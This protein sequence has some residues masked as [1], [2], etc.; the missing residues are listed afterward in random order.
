MAWTSGNVAEAFPGVC[1]PLG[2]SFMHAPV[3]LAL[4][5]A[6]RD[7]GVFTAAQVYQPTRVEE[8]FWTAFAGRAAANMDQFRA[9]ADL[10]P[11]TS[12]TAV[13]QQLFGYVRPG[14]VDRNS[15]RRYPAI[16]VKAPAVVARLGARHDAHFAELR[17]WRTATLPG[18]PALDRGGCLLVLA[19]ARARFEEMMRLHFL[20]SFVGNG[21][22]ERLT[23]TAEAVGGPAL[24]ARLLSGVGSDENQVAADLWDLAHGRLEQTVFLDRHGYHGP[25][26]GQLDSVSWREVPELLDARL[27]DY[28]TMGDASPRAPRLRSATQRADRARAAAELAAALPLP[29][30]PPARLLV[31]LSGR[32]LALREQGKAGYLISFDVARAAA[33]RLG[34]LLSDAGVLARPADV[35]FLT[36]AELRAPDAGRAAALVPA[37]RAAYLERQGQRLPDAWCG[38]PEAVAVV[39]EGAS[40]PGSPAGTVLTGVGAGGGVVE[41]RARV[42]TDPEKTELD[43]GDVLVC[44]A[45]DPSW[46]SLFVVAAGVVTDLGGMLSHGAIVARELGIPCVVGT[47]TASRAIR[48]GQRIRV[49]GERG[50]VELLD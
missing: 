4:R 11:G 49:D 35:F 19:G 36:E 8:Q 6:F 47:R 42:V 39:T 9:L 29:K 37:R 25:N 45:T 1:T 44:E 34:A 12:A 31:H 16:A 46:I 43:E 22:V 3:E 27:A 20:A 23:A 48:D 33:R 26:E 18:V 5:A 10:T 21:V 13:E 28:R 2:F 38:V 14:T 15:Y 17:R 7:I 41:G 24:V 40:G 30:R 32:F 50:V